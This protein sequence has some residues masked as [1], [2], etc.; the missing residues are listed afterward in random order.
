MSDPMSEDVGMKNEMPLTEPA[1][2]RREIRPAQLDFT[3]PA[4]A[5]ASARRSA[6]RQRPCSQERA[7]WWFAQMRRVVEEG[8]EVEVTGVW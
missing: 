6:R 3:L 7:A 5:P 8:R 4:P 2:P 1:A